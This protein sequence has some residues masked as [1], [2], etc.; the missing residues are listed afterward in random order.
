LRGNGIAGSSVQMAIGPKRDTNYFLA[1]RLD[2]QQLSD[3]KRFGVRA[4]VQDS[5]GLGVPKFNLNSATIFY[6]TARRKLTLMDFPLEVNGGIEAKV[7]MYSAYNVY[8]I[9]G[10]SLA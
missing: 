7:S 4:Q 10:A 3:G 9:R 6:E 8:P 1:H 5:T 2:W